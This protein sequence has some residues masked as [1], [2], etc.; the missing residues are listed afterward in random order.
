MGGSCNIELEPLQFV[1][2]LE[3]S[4]TDFVHFRLFATK[5]F[6][7]KDGFLVFRLPVPSVF[8]EFL[9]SGRRQVKRTWRSGAGPLHDV[10]LDHGRGDIGMPHQCLNGSDVHAAFEQV[11]GE[12]VPQGVT[13]SLFVAG[14]ALP[15]SIYSVLLL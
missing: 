11:G 1:Y 10:Q 9:S 15:S 12:G 4:L 3:P 5:N 7:A 14:E 2:Y 13:G 8:P 6:V